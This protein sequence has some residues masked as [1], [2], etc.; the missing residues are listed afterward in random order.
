MQQLTGGESHAELRL[1]LASHDGLIR[2]ASL[3]P[4]TQMALLLRPLLL[5]LLCLLPLVP[6]AQIHRDQCDYTNDQPQ[7]DQLLVIEV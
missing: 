7:G 6:V 5:L 2:K 1:L 3:P 4:E